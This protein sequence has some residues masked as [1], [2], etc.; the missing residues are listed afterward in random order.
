MLKLDTNAAANYS[1]SKFS[2]ASSVASWA[3]PYT[4]AVVKEG[5]IVGNDGRL[6]PKSHISRAEIAVI[7]DKMMPMV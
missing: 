3:L 5:I 4:K 6:E 2:D 1:L 7:L